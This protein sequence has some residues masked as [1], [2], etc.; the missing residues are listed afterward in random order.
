MREGTYH[1]IYTQIN[2]VNLH[3][4]FDFD[5]L[6]INGI[7]IGKAEK[8]DST[9]DKMNSFEGTISGVIVRESWDGVEWHYEWEGSVELSLTYKMQFKYV[10]DQEPRTDTREETLQVSGEFFGR[11]YAEEDSN[12]SFQIRW[13]DYGGLDQ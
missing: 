3:L 10:D 12:T 11:A 2:D 4:E 9:T 7:I 8:F 13:Q 1:S 5:N 6:V